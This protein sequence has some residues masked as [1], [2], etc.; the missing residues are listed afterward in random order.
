MK[1][2][3]WTL[4]NLDKI[5]TFIDSRLERRL[6]PFMSKEQIKKRFES[7]V[8]DKK[9]LEKTLEEHVQLEWTEEN[10]IAQLKDDTEFGIEKASNHRGI[11]ASLMWDVCRAWCTILENGLDEQFKDDY[12]WYGDKLFKA[13]N[14]K[15]NFSLID[16]YTFDDTFYR[17]WW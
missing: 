10:I 4:E 3:Q 6:I 14:E 15:Y 12:G 9:E 11:S 17:G 13:I 2:L 8:E 1:T 5:E 7:N 16:I